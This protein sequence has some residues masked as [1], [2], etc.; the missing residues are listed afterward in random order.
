MSDN[1][2]IYNTRYT[3][4]NVSLV[5]SGPYDDFMINLR[6]SLI[7]EFGAGRDVLDL[8]CGTA[9][10]TLALARQGSARIISCDFSHAMLLRARR[11][12]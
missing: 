4:D 11:T 2:D 3:E 5:T 1:R 6:F 7:R 12:L 8:C 10:L 9:D